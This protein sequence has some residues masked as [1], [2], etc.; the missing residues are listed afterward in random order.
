MTSPT[1]VS[2]NPR[3]IDLWGFANRIWAERL[4]W[5]GVFSVV[6]FVGVWYAMTRPSAYEATQTVALSLPPV[7]STA[8]AIQQ[9]TGQTETTPVVLSRAAVRPPVT[10]AVLERH[11]EITSVEE[12]QGWITALPVGN[13]VEFQAQG[14]DPVA[15]E[16]LVSDMSTAFVES[17]PLLTADNPPALRWTGRVWGDPV[18]VATSSG[19]ML[20]LVFS[21]ASA[22]LLATI[23]A[24]AR[25]SRRRL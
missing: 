8:E 18:S 16:R 21:M 19:R 14:S 7:S 10:D 17:I 4:V 3:V 6:L 1:G 2:E 5:L 23:A 12:L 15:A 11:P 13:T 9:S 25:D 22:A 20:L 24:V